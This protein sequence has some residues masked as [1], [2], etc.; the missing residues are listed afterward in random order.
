MRDLLRIENSVWILWAVWILLLPL[1][2]VMAAAAAACIHEGFHIAAVCLAGGR[3]N[4]ICINPF[5]MVIETHGIHGGREAISALAGPL[6]SLLLL[7]LIRWYPQLSL[8]GLVQGIF[9]L[10]PIYPLDGGRAL[11]CILE[12]FL[13]NHADS[14]CRW[15]E[16]L[17]F[18]IL[19]CGTVFLSSAFGW[20]I[21]PAVL[22]A[23]AILRS[24]LRKRP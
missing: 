10:L 19:F 9:N 21:Y 18:V 22:C 7:L 3:I 6:G 15:A 8:C 14:V 5:G 12:K 2:W 20:G 4:G 23:M 1:K 13:P 16:R 24:Q 17:T 11:G